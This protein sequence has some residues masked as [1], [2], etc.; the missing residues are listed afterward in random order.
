MFWYCMECEWCGTIFSKWLCCTV[1]FVTFFFCHQRFNQYPF[2]HGHYAWTS[3]E[4]SHIHSVSRWLLIGLVAMEILGNS[5][6]YCCWILDSERRYAGDVSCWL[7][8][9]YILA[10]LM[11]RMYVLSICWTQNATCKSTSLKPV[12]S[13]LEWVYVTWYVFTFLSQLVL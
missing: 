6:W 3:L 11:E 1:T 13:W 10:Q 12:V 7:I 8:R 9:W 4:E 5:S 2:C